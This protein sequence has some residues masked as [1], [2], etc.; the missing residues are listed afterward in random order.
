M[1]WWSELEVQ[2]CGRHLV[3]PKQDSTPRAC[4]NSS[5]PEVIQWLPK[6]ESTLHW[7][8][9]A[10]VLQVCH[11]IFPDWLSVVCTRMIGDGICTIR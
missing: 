5:P 1:Q 10:S 3:L 4:R 2:A 6:V 7:E 8:S 9:K 11:I